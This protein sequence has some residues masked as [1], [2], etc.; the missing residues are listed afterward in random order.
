MSQS[1]RDALLQ[2][3][4]IAGLGLI[5]IAMLWLSGDFSMSGD[6]A[7][8]IQ[9]GRNVYAFL[10]RSLGLLPESTPVAGFNNYGALF[11]V[12]ATGLANLLP[13]IDEIRL[14]HFLI[15]ITGFFTIVYAGRSARLLHGRLAE[16][17]CIAML[18]CSPRFFGAAM[19]NSKDIPFALGMTVAAYF[20]LRIVKAAPL[21]DRRL[22]AGLF[23]GLFIAIG[24]R[25]GG[26]M[27]GIYALLAFGWLWRRYRRSY[28]SY[29]LRLAAWLAGTAIAAFLA[30][31]IFLPYIWTDIPLKTLKALHTF[32]HYKVVITMLYMGQDIPTWEPPWH[33]L[34]VWIGITVPVI[35]LLLFLVS[36]LLAGRRRERLPIMLIFS[37]ILIPWVG[38]VALRS[39]VYDAWRQFYFLYPPMAIL[40]AIAGAE[41]FILIKR[42]WLRRLAAGA[43]AAGLLIPVVWSAR[44]H[45]LE[46]VY[47]NELIGGIGGA[48][49]RFET[50][51]YGESVELAC[52]KL[53]RQPAFQ[54]PLADSIYVIN[55]VPPQV[56]HYLKRHDPRIV[57]IHT[58]YEWR[59]KHHW[60]YGIFFTRGLDTL[61]K[62]SDWPPGG[63]IDSV[64]AG[65]TLLMAI[66]KRATAP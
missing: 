9:I 47:F 13:G 25:I 40:A 45:P 55:N 54:K 49:G 35:V 59:D 11:G 27:F 19:N 22:F 38:I 20:L 3:L 37:M 8:Q 46:N 5:G 16:L 42:K 12:L 24:V 48:Y 15:A 60:D 1:G 66:V 29:L 43:L 6:E 65:N 28:R 4:N 61:L 34:P 57:P 64:T 52:R 21:I 17:I 23:A 58:A 44:N 39:P 53:L 10:G 14:R 36:P 50:D 31:I 63:M 32:S 7:S 51:Y 30:A 62:R 33:Y 41:I 2:K 26:L 18:A 56:I